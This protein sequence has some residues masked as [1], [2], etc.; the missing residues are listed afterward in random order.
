MA[1]MSIFPNTPTVGGGNIQKNQLDKIKNCFEKIGQKIY[2]KILENHLNFR[3]FQIFKPSNFFIYMDD[4][5]L[6][7]IKNFDNVSASMPRFNYED[8]TGKGDIPIREAYSLLNRE[9]GYES[10]YSISMSRNYLDLPIEELEKLIEED[11]EILFIKEYKSIMQKHQ[12][13]ILSRQELIF[14]FENANEDDFTQFFLVPLFRKLGFEKVIAK[15]HE[16]KILEFGQDIK[17][18]K[19]RLPTGHYLYFV[20]QVKIGTIGASAKQPTQEIESILTE[21]RPAFHK[22]IFDPDIGKSMK[23]DHVFLITSGRIGEQAKLYLYEQLES[24]D[25]KIKILEREQLIDLYFN[26]GLPESEQN[27]IK[28]FK[29]T[30]RE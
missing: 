30:R 15:G 8:W 18:M 27:K 19:L 10:F 4:V 29:K 12:P 5:K 23:P 13:P 3:I 14:F 22:S 16:E 11:A 17:L 24:Q 1:K 21:I 6:V 20:S 28:Y 26:H 9:L 7:L 25:R 2:E